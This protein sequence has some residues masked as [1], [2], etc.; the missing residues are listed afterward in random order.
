MFYPLPWITTYSGLTSNESLPWSESLIERYE[1]KWNWEWLSI[2]ESLPWSE[3][4]IE[5]YK[6]R[7]RHWHLRENKSMQKLFNRWTKQEINT[8][9]ERIK[10]AHKDLPH[11]E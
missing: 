11:V 10:S 5:R 2:N 3:A 6:D 7:W 9:L 8:A 1:D 4:L